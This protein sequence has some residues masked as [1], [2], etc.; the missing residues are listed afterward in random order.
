MA[1][2][3]SGSLPS[4]TLGNI[5]I[6]SPTPTISS[7]STLTTSNLIIQSG[8]GRIDFIN[9]IASFDCQIL[10]SLGPEIT[11]TVTLALPLKQVYLITA[12]G[13][14]TVSLPR[15]SS[16]FR[17]SRILFRRTATSVNILTFQQADGLVRIQAAGTV[18]LTSGVTMPGVAYTST[19]FLCDGTNWIQL[20][21]I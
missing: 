10:T 2:V 14:T 9:S 8:N 15:A 13:V 17:G 21:A 6:N 11:G 19:E 1:Q 3:S 18:N 16:D 12:T 4:L 20:Y 5:S 7:S